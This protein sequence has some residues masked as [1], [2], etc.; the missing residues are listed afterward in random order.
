MKTGRFS[1]TSLSKDPLE[2]WMG[3]LELGLGP[4]RH[5]IG[6]CKPG[7]DPPNHVNCLILL[8]VDSA[9][10][11]FCIVRIENGA[12]GSERGF[13]PPSPWLPI[14]APNSGDSWR[15]DHNTDEI[16]LC[17]PAIQWLFSLGKKRYVTLKVPGDRC[18]LPTLPSPSS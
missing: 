3:N 7:F 17:C 11:Q 1:P 2:P 15:F 10:L 8:N 13:I 12:A 4:L 16:A 18:R 9:G 6:P 5:K 14:N